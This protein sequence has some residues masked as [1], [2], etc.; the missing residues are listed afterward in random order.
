MPCDV[1]RTPGGMAIVCRSTKQKPRCAYCTDP[2]TQL[3]DHVIA[4]GKTCDTPMC[5]RHAKHVEPNQDYCRQH[6]KDGW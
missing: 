5:R 1:V 2:G 6:L 4:A 3:C